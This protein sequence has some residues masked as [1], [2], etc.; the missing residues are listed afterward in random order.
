M[1]GTQAKYITQNV[2]AI[3]GAAERSYV[4]RLRVSGTVAKHDCIA[5]YLA[6]KVV[7]SLH[8]AR[9]FSITQNAIRSCDNSLRLRLI[10]VACYHIG[11]D[12]NRLCLRLLG[13]LEQNFQR[14][15][16]I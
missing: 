1:I 7:Q 2:W 16:G 9:Q 13:I 3:V 14:D 10:Q 12:A 8:T 11:Q 6:F 4:M 5:A 15:C